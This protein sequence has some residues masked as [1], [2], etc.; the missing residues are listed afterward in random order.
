[1]SPVKLGIGFFLEKEVSYE[2][3]NKV[4]PSIIDVVRLEN[5]L[6]PSAGGGIRVRITKTLGLKF[7]LEV[8]TSDA[9]ANNPKFDWAGKAGI[10]LFL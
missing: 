5:T 10:S 8:W 3:D 9:L 4:G 2:Y 7:G 1:L 6:V